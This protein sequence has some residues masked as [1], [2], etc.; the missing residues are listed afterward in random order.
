MVS[1]SLRLMEHNKTDILE[2]GMLGCLDCML[3]FIN[4]NELFRCILHEFIMYN[5]KYI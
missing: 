2:L 5:A 3:K 4:E 1:G